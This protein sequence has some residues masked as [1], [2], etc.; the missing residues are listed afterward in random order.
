MKESR[1]PLQARALRVLAESLQ[2]VDRLRDVGVLVP[3]GD[4]TLLRQRV[5]RG[6]LC[7]LPAA[8]DSV[9]DFELL[10]GLGGLAKTRA[11]CQFGLCGGDGL[12]EGGGEGGGGVGGG[13]VRG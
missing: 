2:V 7:N 9:T 5:V 1:W 3:V 10:Q 13:A 6:E 11:V 12:D 4:A 8:K